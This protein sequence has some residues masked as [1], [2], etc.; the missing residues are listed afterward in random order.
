MERKV[1]D[2]GLST[3]SCR[4]IACGGDGPDFWAYVA[5]RGHLH[6]VSYWLPNKIRVLRVPRA[7][8][9]GL[10]VLSPHYARIEERVYCR[11]AWVEDADAER[12]RLVPGTRFAHDD[13]RIYAFTITEGLD[14]LEH[15]QRPLYFVSC[16][17]YFADHRHF[18]WQSSWTRRIERIS[19]YARVDDYEK[20]QV[21]TQQ[22][23]DNGLQ[24]EPDEATQAAAFDRMRTVADLFRLA[25]PDADAEWADASPAN[26]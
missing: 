4:V 25:L 16:C 1:Y 6:Y 21:L 17:E 2:L 13:A 12:F 22:W 26:A 9:D 14:V 11:G 8:F 5:D 10:Q 7:S 15:A 23:R 19:G 3:A 18:Y 24:G 20:Q